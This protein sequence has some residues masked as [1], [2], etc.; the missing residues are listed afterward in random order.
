M[1]IAEALSSLENAGLGRCGAP[2]LVVYTYLVSENST[3]NFVSINDL[4]GALHLLSSAG[5][6]LFIRLFT[7]FSLVHTFVVGTQR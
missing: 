2:L 3:L 5:Y 4:S 6:S 7:I 1:G